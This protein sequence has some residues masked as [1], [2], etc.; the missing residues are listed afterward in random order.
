M[1]KRRSFLRYCSIG[2]LTSCLPVI[3]AVCDPDRSIAQATGNK[4]DTKPTPKQPV[5]GFIVAGTTSELDQAGHLQTKAFAVLRNP[6]NP[7]QLIAVNPKCT[8]QG[9]DVKWSV[10]GKK[11]ECPCHGA[12]FD[13][14]G[15]VLNGPATKPLTVYTAKIVSTQVLVKIS[16]PPAA[17]IKPAFGRN[18]T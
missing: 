3:L 2:W 17:K 6:N 9:C 14:D 16:A 8:H 4:N 11:Y 1:I 10:G 7:N 12:S 18:R 15:T 5:D 13:A